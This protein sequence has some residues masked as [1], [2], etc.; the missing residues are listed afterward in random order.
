MLKLNKKIFLFFYF[1]VFFAGNIAV[2]ATSDIGTQLG[3]KLGYKHS[4]LD[5]YKIKP[6]EGF[7]EQ[8]FK[9]LNYINIAAQADFMIDEDFYLSLNAEHAFQINSC[10]GYIINRPKIGDSSPYISKSK[11]KKGHIGEYS[12]L[13][14]YR[15]DCSD[16]INS[17]AII[18]VIG[19][20]YHRVK[21]PTFKDEAVD[22]I[23]KMRYFSPVIG[24]KTSFNCS[25]ESSIGLNAFYLMPKLKIKDE[26]YQTKETFSA[27]HH[28]GRGFKIQLEGDYQINDQLAANLD[29]SWKYLQAKDN[30]ASIDDIAHKTKLKNKIFAASV[31]LSY[32]F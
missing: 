30:N 16:T 11:N 25:S 3:L 20:E 12:L 26:N 21:L 2:Y 27:L 17:Y 28:R 32:T 7:Q 14:G 9:N 5:F 22:L 1:P 10:K 29:I 15:F 31:G 6:N 13:T 8:K 18:P 24:I 19:I 23:D 4:R